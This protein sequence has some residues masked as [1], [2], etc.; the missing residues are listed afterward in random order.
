ME[1][2]TPQINQDYQ[3]RWGK[4]LAVFVLA[5]VIFYA[6]VQTGKGEVKIFD[7]KV[8]RIFFHTNQDQGPKE[9]NWQLLWDAIAEINEKYVNRPA[10]ME[11]VLYGAVSG[12][13]SALE[14]PYSEFLPPRAA[15]EFRDELA[16]NLEGIGAEI[17]I[18]NDLLTVISPLS[19]S[20]AEKAGVKAGDYIEKINGAETRG[21]GIGEAVEKI[22]G[23][24]GTKVVLTV[25]H[26]GLTDSQDIT[27]TRA[28]IEIQSVESEIRKENGKKIGYI[29]MRRFGE[30]TARN[31]ESIV[32]DFLTQNVDGI[33]LDVRNNPGGFLETAVDVASLWVPEG[34]IVVI[35]EFGGGERQEYQSQSSGRLSDVP[36]VV[37]VN[38]GSASASEIVAGALRDHD[39]ATLVGEKSFGKGSVQEVINMRDNADLKLT[40]AKW[41]TPAGH[42]LNKDGLEPDEKVELKD[43]DFAADRDPQMTKALELLAK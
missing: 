39:L 33:I 1:I 6:G 21:L 15:Q 23:P 7:N 36:T 34:K 41:L 8:T 29:K 17:A 22:R 20:P 42:D 43:E 4:R 19:D 31:M 40:I 38:G 12:A 5:V 9:V 14:D 27:I 25:Y 30:D 32:S 2:P 26:K 10:D 35:Q 3:P 18:K 28:K 13:V 11:K 37:L 16:G 24:A